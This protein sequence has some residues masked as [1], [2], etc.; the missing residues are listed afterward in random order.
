MQAKVYFPSAQ[1]SKLL[2]HLIVTVEFTPFWDYLQLD[3][4]VA[5]ENIKCHSHIQIIVWIKSYNFLNNLLPLIMLQVLSQ[6]LHIVSLLKIFGH[7]Q[8]N[9]I[10]T[11]A[12]IL[13]FFWRRW[14]S[15]YSKIAQNIR[16]NN[17]G[18]DSCLKILLTSMHV[19]HFASCEDVFP[20]FQTLL[21]LPF[22][23]HASPRS[24]HWSL[25]P[26]EETLLQPVLKTFLTATV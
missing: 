17:E 8:L 16:I 2:S 20:R 21:I 12:D 25:N 7:T 15:L 6:V 26:L 24:L 23:L 9:I 14:D 1:I 18:P 5:Y 10:S 22:P 4:P 19:D 11:D 13:Y 3:H